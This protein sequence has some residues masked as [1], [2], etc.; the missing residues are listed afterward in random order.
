VIIRNT[1]K[2][3]PDRVR[4]LV[5][6]AVSPIDMRGVCV[7]VKGSGSA[8]GGMAYDYIPS[9]SNA[10]KSC[11]RLVT[12]RVGT[13]DRFPLMNHRYPGKSDR[14]PTYD[15]RT[16]E[17]AL[18]FIAAHEACHIEQ[19]RENK[20]RSELRCETFALGRLKAWRSL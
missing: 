3:P 12:L 18:V 1:S 16:W 14:F 2:Y 7:N 11:E 15:L 6:W 8:F 10:P 5:K 4:E 20:S 19:Y 13:P 17:E 9:I